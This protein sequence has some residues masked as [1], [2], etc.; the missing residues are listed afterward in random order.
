[1]QIFFL[2]QKFTPLVLQEVFLPKIFTLNNFAFLAIPAMLITSYWNNTP[3]NSTLFTN[4][5]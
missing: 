2:C 4:F 3:N 1:M 5:Y